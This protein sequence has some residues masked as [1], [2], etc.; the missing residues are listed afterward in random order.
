MR[1]PARPGKCP[2]PRSSS[3]A[4]WRPSAPT[5]MAA[6]TSTGGQSRSLSSSTSP[7]P[8]SSNWRGGGSVR[9]AARGMWCRLRLGGNEG[10]Q[11]APARLPFH[12]CQRYVYPLRPR[13]PLS[14][15]VPNRR[16]FFLGRIPIRANRPPVEAVLQL[17]ELKITSSPLLSIRVNSPT[18]N[19]G[20]SLGP[21]PPGGLRFCAY[22]GCRPATI[23]PW[24]R[25]PAKSGTCLSRRWPST[26]W[27]F[28][29]RRTRHTSR[30]RAPPVII[31]AAFGQHR[32]KPLRSH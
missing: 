31:D 25:S 29:T 24:M 3:P 15:P 10:R 5:A 32:R 14:S 17:G 7:G 9:G 23:R 20:L 4:G 26:A 16:G 11:P 1:S 22:R 30:W 12:A 27:Q 13:I 18:P 8:Q 2:L 21:P 19:G 6:A 28:R